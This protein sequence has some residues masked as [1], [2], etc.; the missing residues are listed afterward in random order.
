MKPL[1]KY[2]KSIADA[3]RIPATVA[4]ALRIAEEEKPGAVHIE[5]PED[6]AREDASEYSPIH[7]EKIRRP[8]PDPKAI[9]Q[10]I[11]ALKKA[12]RPMILV[13]A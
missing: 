5:L 2:S 7:L 3:V 4:N 8:I 6:I 11:N 9:E 1:T 13:G 10:I 12:K